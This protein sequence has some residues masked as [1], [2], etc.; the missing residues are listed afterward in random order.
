MGEPL[1][2]QARGSRVRQLQIMLNR[3]LQGRALLLVDGQFGDRTQRALRA[4]QKQRG[5]DPSGRVDDATW[6]ALGHRDPTMPQRLR[7]ET[8]HD[9]E[10]L[11]MA[12][13]ELGVQELSKPGEDH[14]RIVEYHASTS[15]SPRMAAKDET[16]W[17]SSFVNWVM[18]HAGFIGTRNAMAKSWLTWGNAENAAAPRRGAITVIF[19][20][21]RSSR[22]DHATGSSSGYHVAFLLSKT[23]DGLYLLGGNQRNAVSEQ[24]F[25]FSGYEIQGYRW[26]AKTAAFA[27]S[28][29]IGC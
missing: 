24:L 7:L 21:H 22:S 4:F 15:L 19:N 10:W 14:G 26:P 1:C 17:C 13:A 16:P 29:F 9:P 3:A 28:R 12:Q 6:K 23:A 25:R 8:A 5:L 18:W 27:R 2:L 11:S 20:K